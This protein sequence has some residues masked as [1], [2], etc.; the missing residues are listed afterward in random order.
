MVI[1]FLDWI[2][3]SN[4]YQYPCLTECFTIFNSIYCTIKTRM[5]DCFKVLNLNTRVSLGIVLTFHIISVLTILCTSVDELAEEHEIIGRNYA[6]HLE[7][8]LEKFG[9]LSRERNN[10]VQ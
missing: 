4:F 1:C 3:L 8:H 7:C 5:P 9:L 2:L 6:H 10:T